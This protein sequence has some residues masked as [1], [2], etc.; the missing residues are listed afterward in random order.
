M[1]VRSCLLAFPMVLAIAGCNGDAASGRA[2]SGGSGPGAGSGGAG[3]G[4][5]TGG[6][7][8]AG[9]PGALDPAIAAIQAQIDAAGIDKSKAGWRT[10]L[11]RPAV[12]TFTPNKTYQWT[13]VTSKGELRLKLLPDAAPMHVTNTIYLTLLGFYDTLTFHRIITGFMAQ[14][15]DPLGNGSGTP[16]YA[17]GLEV[18]PAAKHDA[19]GV[20]SMANAGVDT[21][22]SQFF[23]TFGR[24]PHLDGKHSV[25][26]TLLSGLD[27]LGAIEAAGTMGGTP[28][29]P[30]TITSATISVE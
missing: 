9:A 2:G 29:T 11:P 25:F 24:T 5:G 19:R 12:V 22:G 27:A 26:G 20:L 16:G 17:F 13:L 8:G 14:G 7:P 3:G 30:V 23:V 10:S 21:E 4:A 28:T 6:G 18:S 1:S 15:G